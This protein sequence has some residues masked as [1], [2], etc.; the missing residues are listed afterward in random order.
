MSELT[1]SE[2]A[3]VARLARLS[4][5]PQERARMREQLAKVL[6]HMED[7]KKLDTK[8]VPP[9]AQTLGQGAA[10]RDDVARGFPHIDDILKLSPQREGDYFKVPKVIE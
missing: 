4:L 9:T 2:V 6:A 7:L 5:S 1:D 10:F 8:D 3:H